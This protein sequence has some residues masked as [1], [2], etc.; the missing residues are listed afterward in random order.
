MEQ[1]YINNIAIKYGMGEKSF[2]FFESANSEIDSKTLF[3]MAS[4]TKVMVTTMLGLIA[5]DK[6]MLDINDPVSRFFCVP[7]DKSS[8]TVKNLMTH[9][10]GIGYKLLNLN[11]AIRISL[12]ALKIVFFFVASFRHT[13]YC[14]KL[15]PRKDTD[16]Q[17]LEVQR[18]FEL[19]N[20]R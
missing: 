4:V 12:E 5:I 10:M 14:Q 13:S 15:P 11:E 18:I 2:E 20:F 17:G 1:G 16:F 7:D 3:D 8:M 9:T 19:A 6:S